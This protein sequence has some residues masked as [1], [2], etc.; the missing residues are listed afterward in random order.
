MAGGR[1]RVLPTK[2]VAT[3]RSVKRMPR[4]RAVRDMGSM[5]AGSDAFRTPRV[6]GVMPS[7]RV[8][9]AVMAVMRSGCFVKL[10]GLR[11]A[12]IAFQGLCRL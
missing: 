9:C 3:R 1:R 2:A 4:R 12:A 5:L 7:R 11:Y 6:D 8:W 10:M